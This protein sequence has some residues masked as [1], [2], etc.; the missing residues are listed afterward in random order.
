MNNT[1]NINPYVFP[2]L[3][4]YGKSIF[5]RRL[6][7]IKKNTPDAIITN[8]T[9]LFSVSKETLL[10]KK[11]QRRLVNIRC[12]AI[13]EIRANYPRM[14]LKTIGRI[15]NKDH[16]TIIHSLKQYDILMRFDHDFKEMVLDYTQFTEG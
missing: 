1:Q 8:L 9:E 11:R 13:R 7:A 3:T 15:F 16:S 14:G 4:D 5:Q 6:M 12:I 10:S 2:G